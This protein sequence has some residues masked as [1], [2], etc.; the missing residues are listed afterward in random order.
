MKLALRFSNVDFALGKFHQDIRISPDICA[1]RCM[2]NSKV[3]A[4]SS[5]HE[6]S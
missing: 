3:L 4:P 2:T 1:R 5:A 6:Q